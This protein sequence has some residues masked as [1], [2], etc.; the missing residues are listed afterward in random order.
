MRRARARLLVLVGVMAFAACAKPRTGSTAAAAPTPAAHRQTTP[1][2]RASGVFV[3]RTAL[4]PQALAALTAKYG[5]VPPGRYWYNSASGLWG[6]EG[7]PFSGRIAPGLALGGPM[8]PDISGGGTG[9]F[10]N[11][12]EI[13]PAEYQALLRAFGV[14][15]PGRFWLRPDGWLGPEGGGPLVNLAAA[16]SGGSGSSYSRQGGSV[17]SDANGCSYFSGTG[18]NYAQTWS[19]C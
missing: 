6:K 8:P 13:H 19:N 16:G 9:T 17:G 11:G 4:S 18:S 5:P 14:V 12:R 15:Y 10:I 1:D 3:N 2:A 7:G